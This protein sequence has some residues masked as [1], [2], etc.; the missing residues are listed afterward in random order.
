MAHLVPL[1]FWR[2][3]RIALDAIKPLFWLAETE[4]PNYQDV[5]DCSYA[6]HW[7]H[8]TERFAK[9][10]IGVHNLA[11]NLKLYEEKRGLALPIYFLPAIMTRIVGMAQKYENTAPPRNH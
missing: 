4:H 9:N 6:W 5:F 10:Q 8:E 7:M 1:D 2:D 3:A 11:N